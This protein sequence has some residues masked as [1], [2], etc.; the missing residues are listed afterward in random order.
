MRTR[1]DTLYQ[2]PHCAIA[3]VYKPSELGEFDRVEQVRLYA[4][5]NGSYSL[6]V[7]GRRALAGGREG[8]AFVV[9]G[10]KLSLSDLHALKR[11]IEAE[12]ERVALTKCGLVVDGFE[13][14][15]REVVR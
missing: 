9:A 10:A 5:I 6:Q 7:R 1:T 13:V 11:V 2:E 3:R 15:S 4:D 8:A 14:Q 12:I